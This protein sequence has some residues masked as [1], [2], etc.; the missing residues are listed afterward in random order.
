M[1]IS[2]SSTPT[3]LRPKARGCR[4]KAEATPG[5]GHDIFFNSKGVVA[6][7]ASSNDLDATH[8]GL[9][10]PGS[11][12]SFRIFRET[13]TGNEAGSNTITRPVE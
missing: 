3:E 7:P 8:S 5:Q 1:I 13:D 2:E 12:A 9:S 11:S 4:S 6:L 10:I